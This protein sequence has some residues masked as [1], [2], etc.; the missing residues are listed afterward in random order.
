MYSCI[1]SAKIQTWE[2]P[3]KALPQWVR[4]QQPQA[5]LCPSFPASVCSIFACP[6]SGMTARCWCMRLLTRGC[7]H[8]CKRVCTESWL[9]EGGRDRQT[10]RESLQHRGIEP[11]SVCACF[12]LSFFFFFFFFFFFDSALQSELSRS[13]LGALPT[14]LYRSMRK[15]NWSA[16]CGDLCS[17]SARTPTSVA[18]WL[19]CMRSYTESLCGRLLEVYEELHWKPMWPVDWS[20]W[21]D[22]L[23]ASVAVWLTGK[24]WEPVWSVHW[25]V[26]WGNAL[27]ASVVCWLKCTLRASAVCGLEHVIVR[28][29]GESLCYLCVD[30]SSWHRKNWRSGR[31]GG[32]W[33]VWPPNVPGRKASAAKTRL[34]R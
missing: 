23:R 9:W 18:C 16:C 22:T 28:E 25:N 30:S 12:F 10:D 20:V 3:Q 29:C 26:R 21:G 32:N 17:Y 8:H 11:A 5:Q 6:D 14:G 34:S 13:L 19:K 4:L 27:R 15:W 24:R 33:T 7:F 1:N 31:G 2:P